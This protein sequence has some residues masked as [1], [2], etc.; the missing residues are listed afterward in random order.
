MEFAGH[1]I[2]KYGR[3]FLKGSSNYSEWDVGRLLVLI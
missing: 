2:D 3:S 1:V